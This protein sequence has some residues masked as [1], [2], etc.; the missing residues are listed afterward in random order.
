MKKC[1]YCGRENENSA[2]QCGEC[3]TSFDTDPKDSQAA[4]LPT[5]EDPA[6]AA[7]RRM[8][9]GA[10]WCVGGILVT[11]ITYFSAA[12]SPSGGTYFVAWGAIVFGG[13]RFFQGLTSKNAKPN[14]MDAG[15]EALAYA[16]KLE[17]KGRIEE[18]LVVYQSIIEKYPDTDA[19]NDAKKSIENL[20]VRRD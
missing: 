18:A 14:S 10:L 3:G 6:R 9:S 5:P 8:L 4:K 13:L 19:S 16:A 2:R 1:A 7:E 20:Q 17:T 12:S 11:L 15:Y